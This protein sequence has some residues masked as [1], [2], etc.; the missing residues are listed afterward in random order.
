MMMSFFSIPTRCEG[1]SGAEPH[2]FQ[3]EKKIGADDLQSLFSLSLRC[4]GRQAAEH[5]C[6]VLDIVFQPR[7]RRLMPCVARVTRRLAM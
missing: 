7:N 5:H 1:F 4:C 3:T 6:F 2:P